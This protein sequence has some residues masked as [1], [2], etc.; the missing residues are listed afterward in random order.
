MVL[1]AG[2]RII[3]PHSRAAALCIRLRHAALVV[4]ARYLSFRIRS[5]SS[6]LQHQPVFVVQTGLV[7]FPIR[8]R[9]ARDAGERTDP[10]E[11]GWPPRAHLQSVV[12]SAGSGF[13]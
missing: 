5:V 12:F 7:L 1:A 6:D 4:A 10:L 8:D 2:V 13:A 9:G 3:P 11:Q